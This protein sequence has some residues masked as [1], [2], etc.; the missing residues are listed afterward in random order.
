MLRAGVTTAETRRFLLGQREET[1]QDLE[2]ALAPFRRH[3]APAGV[4]LMKGDPRVVIAEFATRHHT[5]LLVV[6]T[7]A[8]SGVAGR[9][10]GNTAEAVLNQLPCSML[11]VKPDGDSAR[12]R[13]PKP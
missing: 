2:R 13:R 8:R 11:V 12:G 1:R 5:D 7:V 6:G 4:H 10:I 9:I 3:I